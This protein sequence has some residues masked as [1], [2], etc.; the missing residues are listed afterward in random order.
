MKIFMVKG[1]DNK[2]TAAFDSDYD[3]IKKIKVGR[4]IEV[5]II[6]KRN[7]EF[8]KKFFA[9]INMVY[10]NQDHYNNLDELRKDLIISAGFYN[11]RHSF[12]GE[13]IKE[14]KSISFGSMGEEEFQDLYSKVMDEIV[15]HFNFNK[16][17][18]IDHINQYA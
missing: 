6:Q 8:H 17:G 9:L 14:A 12:D 13:E 16:Q 10:S 18:I 1:L 7:I 3:K 2:F 15:I 5:E 4:M 11:V